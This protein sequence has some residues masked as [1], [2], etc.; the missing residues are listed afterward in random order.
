MF[1]PA[2]AGAGWLLANTV[3]GDRRF[4][5]AVLLAAVLPDIDGLTLPF[6]TDSFIKY[7]HILAHNILFSIILSFLAIAFCNE[8]RIKALIFTQ[9][10]FYTHFFGD[11]FLTRIPLYFLYPFSDAS[12]RYPGGLW[13]GHPVNYILMLVALL[14]F[15][16]IAVKWKRTPLE[17]FSPSADK[18]L[19]ELSFIR[20]R[21]RDD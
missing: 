20:E 13:L 16:V 21:E 8:H 15:I 19:V 9:I 1:F 12:Y 18:Q 2:H 5:G 17:L 14:I 7:H 4:R 3:K 6:G 11:Y 10:A